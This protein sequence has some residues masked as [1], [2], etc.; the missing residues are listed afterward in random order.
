MIR[1]LL[2]AVW[3]C[4]IL[5]TSMSAADLSL[6]TKQKADHALLGMDDVIMR[7]NCGVCRI[8][9]KTI[10]PGGKNARVIDDNILVAFDYSNHFYRFDNGN[11][12]KSL[13]TPEFFYEMRGINEPNVSVIRSNASE[14]IVSNDFCELVDVQDIFRFVPV[15]PHMPFKYQ[16]SVLHQNPKKIKKIGY[17][18]LTNELVSVTIE[19]P[20]PDGYDPPLTAEFIINK[21][22]GYT[23]QHAEY[24]CGYTADISWKYINKTWVPVSYVFNSGLNFSVEWKIEWEQVNEKVDNKFFNLEEVIGEQDNDVLMF[25]YELG[26]PSVLVGRVGKGVSTLNTNKSTVKYPYLRPLLIMSGLILI[27]IS[28]CKK[29]YDRLRAKSRR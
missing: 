1:V 15:G 21:A 2:L 29:V 10:M 18:E 5:I 22:N 20:N 8:T 11:L 12:A 23:L 13:L 3:L 24:N 17:K 6:D 4:L 28:L 27:F 26:S 19:F 16:K 14:P 25:S 9:G 7:I